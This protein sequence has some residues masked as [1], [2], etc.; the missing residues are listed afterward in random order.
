MAKKS[1]SDIVLRAVVDTSGVAAGLNNI[2]A[3]V[4]GRQF[5][6]TAGGPTGASGAPGGFVNPH[7]GGAGPGA[8]AV[9]AA[10]VA[11]AAAGRAGRASFGTRFA[12][13]KGLDANFAKHV[14]NMVDANRNRVGRFLN[15]FYAEP[16]A[17]KADR[18]A[19]MQAWLRDPR[20]MGLSPADA[21]RASSWKNFNRYQ[22]AY[23][24]R[25]ARVASISRGYEGFKR[26]AGN[27]LE[28]AFGSA[29][30]FAG[31]MGMGRF[32][33]LGGGAIM[34]GA[35]LA[36]AAGI[37]GAYRNRYDSAT[38]DLTRFNYGEDRVAAMRMR[39]HWKTPG[40]KAPLSLMDRFQVGGYKT[41]NVPW[42][43]RALKS[44]GEF[45]G[46]AAEQGGAEAAQMFTAW[47]LIRT[48]SPIYRVG[49][50]VYHAIR[51]V[52]N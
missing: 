24:A 37:H 9:A 44:T 7:G 20:G 51:R 36:L 3:Q 23:E 39:S 28:G 2:G 31:L 1:I 6:Q 8:A 34:A 11:G 42:W 4:A 13:A 15:R 10:A 40:R 29:T 46:N 52:M 45:I 16:M 25:I 49:E 33:P 12:A 43:D 19:D 47:G 32:A 41:G 50:G 48:Y 35:P 26:G 30:R 18:Y 21:R 5:G 17:R 38:S 22:S 14:D 27:L